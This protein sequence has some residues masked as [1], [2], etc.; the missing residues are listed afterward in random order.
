MANYFTLRYRLYPKLKGLCYPRLS[1]V[2]RF[3][4]KFHLYRAIAITETL[5]AKTAIIMSQNLSTSPSGLIAMS[6]TLPILSIA[7]IGL[8]FWL[9]GRQKSQLKLDDWLMLPAL[10]SPD[11]FRFHYRG[12]VMT[13]TQRLTL[14]L[15]ADS[16]HW[17]VHMRHSRYEWPSKILHHTLTLAR[18]GVHKRA[19]GYPNLDPKNGIEA[20]DTCQIYEGQVSLNTTI[21]HFVIIEPNTFYFSYW[22]RFSSYRFS[23]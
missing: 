11:P 1:V 14:S 22:K 12:Q 21:S 7:A 13:I 18:V 20:Y 6:C 5:G 19:W 16:I 10:V 4:L 9:R 23:P 8:R 3:H 17:H 2:F 15:H